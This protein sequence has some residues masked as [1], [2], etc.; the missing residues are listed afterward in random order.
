MVPL[1]TGTGNIRAPPT[2]EKFGYRDI[3]IL[4]ETGYRDIGNIYT[5]PGLEQYGS[6]AI[7]DLKA[8]GFQDTGDRYGLRENRAGLC[9]EHP[10]G[11]FN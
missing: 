2:K 5:L 3:I 9:I 11:L 8:A 4:P 7:G 6:L 10:S 1:L